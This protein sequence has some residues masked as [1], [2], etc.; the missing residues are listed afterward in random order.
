[1]R[2]C[3]SIPSLERATLPLSTLLPLLAAMLA[4]A[5]IGVQAP[6]NA[7]LARYAAGPVAAAAVSFGVGFVLLALIAAG[8]GGVGGLSAAPW[9]SW[10][11]G[12]L[13]A[14]YV[15]SIIYATPAI[16]ALSAIMAMVLG[17]MTAAMIV[18]ATGAFGMATRP[19]SL[20][21]L[22][23]A[24]CVVLGLLLSRR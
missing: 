19:V 2:G 24:A 20:D 12:A 3:A 23:G 5:A 21:R 7:A 22:A 18:D 8:R 10:T 6:L 9:W 15:V 4:G 14:F 1:M 13:G 11:G 17:Q 16:G